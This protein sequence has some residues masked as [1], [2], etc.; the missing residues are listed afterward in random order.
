MYYKSL[1][2]R[3][4]YTRSIQATPKELGQKEKPFF[5]LDKSHSTKSNKDKEWVSKYTLPQF[6]KVYKKKSFR[7]WSVRS[8]SLNTLSF[9]SLHNV[10]IK[11][12]GAT[13]QAF[14]LSITHRST[15]PSYQIPF[16]WGVQD[17][18]HV[19]KGEKQAP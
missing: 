17:P 1:E 19:K 6:T 2:R 4:E 15:M 18:L 7:A 9:L 14:F 5:Y 10:H 12:R 16:D 11:Q 3:K 8:L 13:L